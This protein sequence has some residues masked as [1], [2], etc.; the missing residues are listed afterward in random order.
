ME[1]IR[2]ELRQRGLETA[3]S[4]PELVAR[5]EEDRRRKGGGCEWMGRV[6]ELAAHLGDCEWRPVKCLNKGCAESPLQRD[7]PEHDLTCRERKVPCSTCEVEMPCRM[8]AE[9]EEICSKRQVECNHCGEQ[10]EWGSL[11]EHE[12][13]CDEVQIDCPNEGCSVLHQRGDMWSH[14]EECGHEKVTCLCPG[15]DARIRRKDQSQHV[16]QRHLQ[17]ALELL[18][19]AWSENAAMVAER[20]SEQ[21]HA[22]ATETT[23][24][25]NWRASWGT[26]EFISSSSDFGGLGFEGFCTLREGCYSEEGADDADWHSHD[27]YFEIH[28]IDECRAHATFS[29]LDEHDKIL[30]QVYEVGTADEPVRKKDDCWGG[31]FTPTAEDTAQSVR[32]DGSIRLRAV[33]RL[34]L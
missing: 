21:R 10:M 30:C 15:C 8:L 24:V 5:L 34:F 6:G 4:K 9:H 18:E 12:E 28:G 16:Q 26:G 22:A 19:S 2:E 1:T 7:L 3:G 20:E 31:V 33:V 29:V 27:I 11:A 25:F 32:A 17:S 13:V 23:R 14:R